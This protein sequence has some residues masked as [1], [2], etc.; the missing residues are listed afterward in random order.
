MTCE[1][2]S[3][4]RNTDGFPETGDVTVAFSDARFPVGKTSPTIGLNRSLT[5][6]FTTADEATPITKPIARPM[7]PKVWRKPVNSL[8]NPF[9]FSVVFSILSMEGTFCDS[10]FITARKILDFEHHKVSWRF[11]S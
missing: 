7:T 1:M 10:V 9:F 2:K 6:E 11:R 4:Y 3:P 5:R 8:T